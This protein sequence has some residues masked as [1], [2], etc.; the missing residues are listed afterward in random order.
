M[1]KAAPYALGIDLG[2][3]HVFAALVS[4]QGKILDSV[5]VE[6]D[7]HTPETVVDTIAKAVSRVLPRGK[8]APIGVG[9]GSP[10]NIDPVAGFVRYSPNFGWHDVPLVTLLTQRLA[11]PVAIANDARC[12]TLGEY[13]FGIGRGVRDFVLLTLGT[14]IG[15]GIIA[16]G[17]IVLGHGMGAGEVGHHQIRP[18]DGFICGCGKIGCFEAQASGLG[19]LRHAHRCAASFPHSTLL[20]GDSQDLSAKRIRKAMENGDAH[21]RAAWLAYLDDLAI[22]IANIVAMLNPE[23]IALGG[24]VASAG[25][26]LREPLAA[27]VDALTT[28]APR[29]TTKILLAQ[30]GN[31]AGALGAAQLAFQG[32]HL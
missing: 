29:G 2:G 13:T 22:G 27:R 1:A 19:L 14:G 18:T 20:A 23:M 30:F 25:E 10:G 28:M 31:D 8:E 11:M 7:D 5:S 26:V 15:G 21:A 12:A 17:R 32:G 24:G 6:N 4:E 9:I 16:D 3:S